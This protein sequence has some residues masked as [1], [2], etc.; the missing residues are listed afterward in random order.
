MS[1]ATTSTTARRVGFKVKDSLPIR[2][3]RTFSTSPSSGVIDSDVVIVGGGP[4]GLALASA[5]RSSSV[6]KRRLDIT[7]VEAGDLDKIRA[8]NPSPGIYSNRVSSLTNASQSFLREIGA[9][10]YVEQDRTSGVENLRVWDGVSDARIDFSA[11]TCNYPSPGMARLTENLNLQRG[12]LRHMADIRI[13]PRTKVTSISKDN[14]ESGGWPLVKLDDEKVLRARLLVGADGFNSPVRAFARISSFGWSYDTQAIVAT[15][16]HPP[17]GVY[18]GPNTTAYQRF[19]PTGPI[20]FLPLGPTVSSLVW[21]TK[22]SLAAALLACESGVLANMINA[23]FR[24]PLISLKYLHERILEAHAKAVPI[25]VT[26]I[27]EEIGWREQSHM[28]DVNSTYSSSTITRLGIP[29]AD[30]EDVPPLVTEIQPGPFRTNCPRW[31]ELG[32]SDVECLARCIRNALLT[33]SDIGSYTALLPYSQERYLANHTLMSAV[34]K[35]HKLFSNESEPVVWAR[36]VGFEVLNELDTVKAGIMM[37]A[38]AR[39]EK[40]SSAGSLGWELTAGAIQ[41]LSSTSKTAGVVKDVVGSAVSSTLSN[42]TVK[43]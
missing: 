38:G 43:L 4:A 36:S 32:L 42:L 27:Q 40:K 5:L 11:V 22:P 39:P 1:L 10:K 9:W 18:E 16:Y 37:T 2:H 17:R 19:L 33:G 21:S 28:I 14:E 34:D 26:E 12:L 23:A 29:P 8:W 6:S 13:I 31:P 24:L 30:S 7:L 25:S 20:A 3:K 15:M 41:T 35:L